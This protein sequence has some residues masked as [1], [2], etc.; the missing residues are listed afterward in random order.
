MRLHGQ[1]D[2]NREPRNKYIYDLMFDMEAKNTQWEWR[3]CSINGKNAVKTEY[4]C[5]E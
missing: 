3:V 1:M 5:K 4:P 2:E